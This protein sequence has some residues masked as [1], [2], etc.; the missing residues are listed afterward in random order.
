MASTCIFYPHRIKM[1]ENKRKRKKIKDYGRG[2]EGMETTKEIRKNMKGGNGEVVLEHVLNDEALG[3]KCRLYAKVTLAPGCSIGYHTHAGEA[4]CFYFLSGE[5][6]FDDNGTKRNVK[7][8]D[9]TLTGNG[10][11]HGI[12]NAGSKDLVFMALIL[13]D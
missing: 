8:G 13:L 10:R 4:V 1:K 11:G 5:G 12:E 6:L 7:P 9:V 3:S 2:A